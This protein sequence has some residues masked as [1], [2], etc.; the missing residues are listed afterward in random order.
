MKTNAP[1]NKTCPI[2]TTNEY[3]GGAPPH[4]AGFPA[5]TEHDSG[6]TVKVPVGY[7]VLMFAMAI[8]LHEAGVPVDYLQVLL[9][10]AL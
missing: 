2:Q 5:D 4:P 6:P 1:K 10:G 3:G 7:I 9:T 8:G